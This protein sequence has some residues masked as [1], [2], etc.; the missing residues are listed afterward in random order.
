ML[1][2]HCFETCNVCRDTIFSFLFKCL[3]RKCFRKSASGPGSENSQ[4]WQ[5]NVSGA[6][7]RSCPNCVFVLIFARWTFKQLMELNVQR[8]S[9]CRH[10]KG[11]VFYE[12]HVLN[13][14]VWEVHL[15][16]QSQKCN[17]YISTCPCLISPITEKLKILNWTKSVQKQRKL[18]YN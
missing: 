8:Q 11:R 16:L 5:V 14:N 2:K 6:I 1:H 18:H 15:F 9:L 7:S 17:T 4:C 13:D 3:L 12:H 10:G